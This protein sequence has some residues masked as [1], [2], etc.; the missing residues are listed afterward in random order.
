MEPEDSQN[1]PAVAQVQES[2]AWDRMYCQNTPPGDYDPQTT[3]YGLQSVATAPTVATSPASN[4]T[5]NSASLHGTVNANG[6]STTAWF[7]YRI[8]NGPSKS[9]FATQTVIGTIDAEIGIRIIM[10]LPG[11]TYYYRLVAKNDAGTT[12][13]SEVSFTT[14]DINT[15]VTTEITPPIGAISINSGAYCTNSFTVTANLSATDNTGVTGYYLSTNATPPSQYTTGWMSTT[16]AT[17]YK[18]DVT[19]TISNGDGR[20]MVY[21]WYKD[22]SGNISDAAAASIVVDTTPPIITITDPTS[23]QTYTTKSNVVSISG[24]ASDD[25]NEISSVVWIHDKDTSGTER[26]TIG[27]TVPNI[28]LVKGENVIT[29][30]ATD[31]VGNTGTATI[32]ITYAEVDA[33]PKVITGHA[34]SIT[35]DLATLSGTV[36]AM[37][38]PATAWFQ[39]GTSSEH[40]SG[41]S[42]IQ[43]I[44][45]GLHEVPVSNRISGLQAGT[46]YYYRLVAQ[47]S[48][49]ATYGNEITFNTLPPKGNIYG[50][51]VSFLKEGPV[52][53]AKLQLKGTKARKKSFK[54]TFSDAH[55]FFEFKDLDADTYDITVTKTDFKSMSQTVEIEEGERKKIGIILQKTKEEDK[56]PP[57]DVKSDQQKT[58]ETSQMHD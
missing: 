34:T 53:S 24:S 57:K 58:N 22:A 48:A 38:L 1:P 54:V 36:N 21:V 3:A 17:T 13:G 49:G 7:Q 14:A 37:G 35:T 18:E 52:E 32:T 28:G 26:K 12:Y 11:T 10:L 9:T 41:T 33:T 50:N 27:W 15:S 5:H 44:E 47:N 6:L 29:I 16:P 19:Y 30:K 20:N 23:D 45:N 51:V 2:G 55:G 31:S 56:G 46:A 43:S 8:A 40:Y 39:Y 4:V 42:S 25:I